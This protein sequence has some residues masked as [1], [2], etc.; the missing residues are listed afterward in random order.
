[1][2]PRS[3]DGD[4]VVICVEGTLQFPKNERNIQGGS[5][6]PNEWKDTFTAQIRIVVFSGN[7]FM[8]LTNLFLRVTTGLKQTLRGKSKLRVRP[9]VPGVKKG[10]KSVRLDSLITTTALSAKSVMTQPVVS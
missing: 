8:N 5:G 2:E 4:F 3:R 10:G 1:M 7:M 9:V 6:N